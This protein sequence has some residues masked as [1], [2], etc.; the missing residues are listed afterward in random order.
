MAA[1]RFR[2][3][4]FTGLALGSFLAALDQTVVATALPRI[5]GDLGGLSSYTWLATAYLLTATAL[6]PLYGRLSD[7]YGRRTPYLIALA[8]FVVGSLAAAAAQTIGELVAARAVQGA[9]AAGLLTLALAV[10]GDEL[11]PRERAR[12]QGLFGGIFALASLVGPPLGGALTDTVGWRWIFAL[13]VP[14]GCTAAVLL[15]PVLSRTRRLEAR[16]DYAGAALLIGGVSALLLGIVWGGVERPWGS[17]TILGLLVAG[18]LL[19]AAFVA[20]EPR[21]PAP[22]LP[23]RLLRERTFAVACSA[24]FCVGACLF[25]AIFF[26]PLFLQVAEHRSASAAGRSLVILTLALVL[27]AAISGRVISRTGKLRIFPLTGTALLTA[28]FFLLRQAATPPSPPSALTIPLA[29][30]GLGIGLVMQVLVL[31]VQATAPLD[32]LGAATSAAGFFRSIGGT[33]GTAALG[34]LLANRVGAVIQVAAAPGSR[35]SD[36][37]AGQSVDAFAAA[38][39]TVFLGA[40]GAAGLAFVLCLFLPAVDVRGPDTARSGHSQPLGGPR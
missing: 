38:M 32:S 31:A 20:H 16:V 36:V 15:V 30:I 18:V 2:R 27:G 26:V 7:H 29:V 33:I 9:G 23:L 24:G 4:L 21:V 25:G 37:L 12:Y 14:L 17:A 1:G 8:V 40:G 13:N 39:R 11:A 5:V 28:G 3:R 6:T 34:A 35:R 19:V 22:I 10:V